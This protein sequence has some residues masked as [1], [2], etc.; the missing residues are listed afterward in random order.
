[1]PV[2]L[3]VEKVLRLKTSVALPKDLLE[4]AHK[5]AARH[6]VSMSEYLARLL[7]ADLDERQKELGE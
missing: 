4:E 6:G 2:D 1:M 7:R 5:V 3:N